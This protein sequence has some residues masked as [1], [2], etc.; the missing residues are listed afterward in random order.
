MPIIGFI[1]IVSGLLV[2]TYFSGSKSSSQQTNPPPQAQVQALP[3]NS[4][5]T[6]YFDY[7]EAKAAGYSDQ[8]INQYLASK[9]QVGQP[10]NSIMPKPQVTKPSDRA[11]KLAT[12]LFLNAGNQKTELTKKFANGTDNLQLAINNFALMLDKDPQK[13]TILEVALFDYLAKQQSQNNSQSTLNDLDWKLHGIENQLDDIKS[14][15]TP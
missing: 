13:T 4:S 1:L 6:S 7:A 5:I 10:N 8:E 14:T 9:G 3:V 15:L 12:L 2:V 11:L